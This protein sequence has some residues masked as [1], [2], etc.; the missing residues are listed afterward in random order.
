ME[1][2]CS[3]DVISASTSLL[4]WVFG[5]QCRITTQGG[6]EDDHPLNSSSASHESRMLVMYILYINFNCVDEEIYK[7]HIFM[8]SPGLCI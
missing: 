5:S 8:I 6:S 3:V 1:E 7:A 2:V 4:V